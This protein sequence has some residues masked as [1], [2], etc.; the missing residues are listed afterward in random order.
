M[1]IRA[2][3]PQIQLDILHAS[4]ISVELQVE[5]PDQLFFWLANSLLTFLITNVFGKCK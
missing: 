3:A 4:A 2:C 1:C 5:L